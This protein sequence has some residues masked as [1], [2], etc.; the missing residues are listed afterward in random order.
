M[1]RSVLSFVAGI[2]IGQQY[3][4]LPRVEVVVK[5]W[6][7]ELQQKLKQYEKPSDDK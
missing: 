3:P 1:L 2:H 7:K 6:Q 5:E 4:A